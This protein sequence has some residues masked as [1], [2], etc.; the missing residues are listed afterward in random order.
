MRST[1]PEHSIPIPRTI[2]QKM[3]GL[4]IIRLTNVAN[5]G[6]SRANGFHKSFKLLLMKVYEQIASVLKTE[7]HGI[8]KK[9]T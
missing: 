2:V 6:E 9:T 7:G 4:H 1:Y 5:K 3:K 8:G